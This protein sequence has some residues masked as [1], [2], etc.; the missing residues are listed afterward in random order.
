MVAEDLICQTVSRF[1]RYAKR[2]IEIAPVEKGGSDRRYYRVRVT[3]E[4][5]LILVKY[6]DGKEENRH[7]V[8][9]A[10]FLKSLG[11]NVPE[12][13]FH[14]EHEG[15][16]WM[17]DLGQR[18]LCSYQ[19]ESWEARRMLYGAALDE[20][21]KLHVR[22]HRA[23]ART[24]LRLQPE[25]DENL[26]TWEQDYFIENC[27]SR[28]FRMEQAA[29][30][31]APLRK[32]AVALS[33]QPRALV[34][35]DFQS[36][37]IM[38]SDEHDGRAF[39]IDFQGLRPGLE[40]Y[41]VASLIYDPYVT[42]SAGERATLAS[43]YLERMAEAGSPVRDDFA[44]TLALCAAQRLMQALGAYGYLGLVKN[45][46]AFLDHIPA[47]LAALS[48]VLHDIPQLGALRELLA[49]LPAF[50]TGPLTQGR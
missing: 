15:L 42:L 41:D 35:R 50:K 30:D 40:C 43:D 21:V 3:D 26:Y 37:N 28:C 32:I 49:A 33:K 45:R 8:A 44:E 9:I 7:Y 36:Q 47:A 6:G 12:I 39:M 14:D 1:P 25:F 38:I 17:E 11:V 29:I 2:K 10:R 22:G 23:P 48:E 4:H 31:P 27:L 18:D 46:G 20:L 24:G 34:H 16:I 13:F 5:S 19:D